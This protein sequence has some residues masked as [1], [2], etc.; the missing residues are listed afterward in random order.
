MN[1][2][3][4]GARVA[5]IRGG[6]TPPGVKFDGLTNYLYRTSALSGV[7]ASGAC[8]FSF[9][10]NPDDLISSPFIFWLGTSSNAPRVQ[11]YLNFDGTVQATFRNGSSTLRCYV[12]S[13][14]TITV[15]APSHVAC[16]FDLA[17][18]SRR[19]MYVSGIQQPSSVWSVYTTGVIDIAFNETRVDVG[20]SGTSFASKYPGVLSDFWF[21]PGTYIDLSLPE[22]LAKFR[23]PNNRPEQLGPTGNLVTGTAPPVYMHG[24]AAAGFP[25]VGT[26]GA[27]S[28]GGTLADGSSPSW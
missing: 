25:N 8:T 21:L 1:P 17:S 11:I 16:S 6:Y 27:F 2:A 15:G 13:N 20:A 14:T 9:W 22:N 3:L 7:A 4:M 18:T 28:V 24:F 10:V 19:W 23:R 5:Q 26:G 12:V